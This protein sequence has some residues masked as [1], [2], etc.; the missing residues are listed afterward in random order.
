MHIRT[1]T[2]LQP[3]MIAAINGKAV[4]MTVRS[5][6]TV[7]KQWEISDHRSGDCGYMQ[8]SPQ[9]H[10][11]RYWCI[12]LL[13]NKNTG[14]ELRPFGSVGKSRLVT[15]PCTGICSGTVF[16]IGCLKINGVSCSIF[17]DAG[18]PAKIH[19]GITCRREFRNNA[20]LE[21]GEKET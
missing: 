7:R 8:L 19:Q 14:I 11:S 9:L 2:H 15:G 20:L 1:D 12:P 6:K 18:G 13:G 5:D 4:I 21:N 10:R 17:T 16:S 3:L